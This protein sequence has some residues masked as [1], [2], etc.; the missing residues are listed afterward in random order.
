MSVINLNEK[1]VKIEFVGQNT[2][3]EDLFFHSL[4]QEACLEFP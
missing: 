1:K 3:L 4:F 2:V